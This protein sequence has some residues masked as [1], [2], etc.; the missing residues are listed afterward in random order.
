MEKEAGMN[1]GNV[2]L[3]ERSV[4][5]NYQIETR[6][7]KEIK[8]ELVNIKREAILRIFVLSILRKMMEGVR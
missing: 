8:P 4:Y 2:V 6:Y 1:S 7:Y 3:V 5:K